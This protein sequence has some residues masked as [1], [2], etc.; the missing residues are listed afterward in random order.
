VYA[1]IE[2]ALSTTLETSETG[3][4]H[5]CCG[6]AGR[7]DFLISAG[8]ALNRPALLG[9]A[10]SRMSSVVRRKCATGQYML[11]TDLAAGWSCPV[12]FQGLAGVGYQLLRTAIPEKVPSAL[13]WE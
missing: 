11:R 2:A 10:V 4:D 1:D 8:L 6:H 3:P 7:I 5:L 12:F 9:E 13:S